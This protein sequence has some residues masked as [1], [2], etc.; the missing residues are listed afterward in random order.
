M[1]FSR[2]CLLLCG[3]VVL[4]SDGTNNVGLCDCNNNVSIVGLEGF[5]PVL[6]YSSSGNGF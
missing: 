3:V 1:I 2:F 5:S 6:L 4:L